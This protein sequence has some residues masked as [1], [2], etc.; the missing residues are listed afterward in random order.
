MIPNSYM[1]LKDILHSILRITKMNFFPITRS[2]K[3]NHILP[4]PTSKPSIRRI[5]RLVTKLHCQLP[6]FLLKNRTRTRAN[7]N[8]RNTNVFNSF[9]DQRETRAL[10]ADSKTSER[11]VH[12]VRNLNASSINSYSMLRAADIRVGG[13]PTRALLPFKFLT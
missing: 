1:L 5:K 4:L 12:A 11:H 6:E 7:E 2:T 10:S 3:R 8:K 9:E 13:L